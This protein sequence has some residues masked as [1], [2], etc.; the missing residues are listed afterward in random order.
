MTQQRRR[1]TAMVV[2]S[3]LA[4]AGALLCLSAFDVAAQAGTY[5]TYSCRTPSG[6]V[7]PTTGWSEELVAPSLRTPIEEG[8]SNFST[9]ATGGSLATA[10]YGNEAWRPGDR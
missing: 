2:R 4:V 8:S 9:C 5:T 10:L 3:I 1:R 7:A 6:H